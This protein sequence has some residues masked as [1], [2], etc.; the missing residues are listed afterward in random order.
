M[1]TEKGFTLI[2]VLASV[3]IITIILLSFSQIFISN[4]KYAN[5][6]TE[7]LVVMNL[8]DA[9]LE[10]LR[11]TATK[12]DSTIAFPNLMMNGKTYKV[13]IRTSQTP[14]EEKMHIQNVIVNVSAAD[15]HASTT[16]EGYVVYE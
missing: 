13:T 4:N 9:Q 6:N 8:A 16:V 7:K 15:S 1:K 11:V 14:D 10:R 2:E 12:V 3:I 5:A